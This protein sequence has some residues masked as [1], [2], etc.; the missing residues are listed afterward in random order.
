MNKQVILQDLSSLI[1]M[2]SISTDPKYFQE[3]LK[4]VDFLTEKLTLL[5]CKIQVLKREGA[6]PL[7]VATK[8]ANNTA[9]TIGIYAHYDVQPE[10][11]VGEW[12]MPPFQLTNLNGKLRGRG[13]ADDKGHLI[14]IVS[15]V[16]E[17]IE[18]QELG[19]NV[20]FIF[21]GEEEIGSVHLD[22]LLS[23]AKETLSKVDA[24][25]IFDSGMHAKNMP[26]IFYGLRGIIYFELEVL[27]GTKDLHS[28]IYGNAVYNP[29]QILSEIIAHIKDSKSGRILIPHFYD[30]VR[31][32]KKDELNALEELVGDED[33]MRQEAG[34][35]VTAPV[36]NVH[37]APKIEPAF[38]CNGIVGGYT[39]AGPKTVIPRSA[40]AKF[41]FR[42]IENQNPDEIERL[43]QEFIVTL[44]PKGVRHTL[45]TISKDAPFYTS[46]KNKYVEKT[47]SILEE[48]FSHKTLFNRS[49]GSIPVAELLQ[50]VFSKPII[51]TGFTLPDDNLHAPNEN[52][53]EEM[54]WKGIEALKKIFLK[55]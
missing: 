50:R 38:D 8:E 31:T 23:E 22:E 29:I 1:A 4:A 3:L 53:D 34:V 12:E 5:D 40:K 47:A 10:D 17:L 43:V 51:V 14:Q 27:T 19:V 55:M 24:F 35:F 13:V 26:Q 49:G 33:S 32:P 36:K 16:L 48:T 6:A 7:I 41:S 28:G 52:F 37:L 42:L 9:S 25:Y 46:L 21:E 2:K 44:L 20:V 15:A 39:G 18:K 45:T 11:P 54:F 30:A